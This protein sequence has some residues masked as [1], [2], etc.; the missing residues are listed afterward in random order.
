MTIVQQ[1][2]LINDEYDV[3][4]LLYALLKINFEDIRAEEYS[5]S[6]AGKN[7]RI[8]FLLKNEE[9]LLE[10]KK[11]RANLKDSGIGS[12]LILD[13]SR[14][15]NH[16]SCKILFC[17]VYDPESLIVNPRGLENDLMSKSS[18]ELNVIVKIVP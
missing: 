1:S 11:T 6:Y 14:Y 5:P 8:D 10:V 3:Q 17:L 9:I 12:E 2:I 7:T 15:Q 13:I 16:P 4:D 18:H